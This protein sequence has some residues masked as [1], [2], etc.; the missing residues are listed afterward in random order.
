MRTSLTRT[1]RTL[2]AALAAGALA[3]TACGDDGTDAGLTDPDQTV[4][5]TNDGQG[6][7]VGEPNGSDDGA[8]G[9]TMLAG[10]EFSPQERADMIFGQ[11]EEQARNLALEFGWTLR[12]SREDDMMFPMTEDYMIDRIT[13]ELDHEGED[14]TAVVTVVTIELEGGP[15]TFRAG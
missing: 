12:V 14:D 9:G 3:L 2:V 1:S 7:A 8:A 6:I 15:E 4:D 10:S 13:V 5:N 11:T